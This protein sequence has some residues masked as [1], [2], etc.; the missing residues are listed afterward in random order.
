MAR[1]YVSYEYYTSKADAGIGGSL[2]TLE[3]KANLAPEK[4]NMKRG[5]FADSCR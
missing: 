4:W 3:I 1:F 2:L 5:A